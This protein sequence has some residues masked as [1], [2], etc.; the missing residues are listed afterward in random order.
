MTGASL[1]LPRSGSRDGS[2]S[3]AELTATL[4]FLRRVLHP[5]RVIETHAAFVLLAG[6]RAYK[7]KKP[8]NLG[9]FDH[10]SLA[11]REAA[12]REELRLNRE[13]A[14]RSVYL[15]LLPVTSPGGSVLQLGGSGRLVDWLVVMR[16]LPAQRMLDAVLATGG[17]PTA[18]EIAALADVLIRFYG[19]QGPRAGTAGPYLAHLRRETETNR[20]ALLHHRSAL[21]GAALDRLTAAAA[22]LVEA[23]AP[24]IA[25]RAAAGLI[26]EGHGDLR[27]EHVCLT[28]PPTIF[29]RVEFSP[30]LRVIDIGDE[31]NTLALE[32][33]LL[34]AP[35]IGPAIADR[36]A[37]AG[38][39]PLT[40]PLWRCYTVFRCLTR[41]RLCIKHLDER[42]PRSPETWP[43]R[44]MTYL[45]EADR[46]LTAPCQPGA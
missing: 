18:E 24:A 28:H 40:C 20:A 46:V 29:D 32:C 16:R 12:C 11:A 6:H 39:A 1:D 14:G 17:H 35:E 31:V 44:A 41:A 10:R 2:G 19:R 23:A 43:P 25:A 8:V 34:G 33:R 26:L 3:Q 42:P 22:E 36:L 13:L 45:A 38:F 37:A 4:A 5:D 15:G 27:P 7:L 21:P 9:A 30:A